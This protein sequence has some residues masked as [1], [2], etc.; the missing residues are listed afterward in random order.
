MDA[1]DIQAISDQLQISKVLATY[2]R[3]I[4]RCDKELLKTVYWPEAVDEHGIFNGNALEFAEFIVPLLQRMTSTM[5]Q[6]SNILINLHGSGASVETYCVAYHSVPEADGRHT[7]LIVGG[8]YLDVFERRG[9]EW[10]IAHRTYVMDW[11]ESRPS[12]ADWD[13]GMMAQ[14]KVRGTH[15]RSDPSYRMSRK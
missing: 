6:I 8:R 5:H 13:S 11:N 4:D 12:T 15:D 2:C 9:A 3:A 14:L 10:R 1:A 7:E